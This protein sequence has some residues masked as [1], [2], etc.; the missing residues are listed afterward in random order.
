M[1]LNLNLSLEDLVENEEVLEDE[2]EG[3]EPEDVEEGETEGEVDTDALQ[4]SINNDTAELDAVNQLEDTIEKQADVIAEV[5]DKADAGE[6][7]EGDLAVASEVANESLIEGEHIVKVLTGGKF[8]LKQ[9]ASERGV[10]VSFESIS[11]NPMDVLVGVNE[12]LTK[13]REN[14]SEEHL[15][16]LRAGLWYKN[17]LLATTLALESI[18]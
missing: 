10:D 8:G 4:E 1:A 13:L 15:E 5:A 18:D 14:I 9:L 16:D 7:T 12:S 6:L 11:S 2:V 3:T 17:T